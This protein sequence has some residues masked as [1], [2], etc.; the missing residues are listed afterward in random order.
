M[1]EKEK[2]REGERK[3]KVSGRGKWREGVGG[4]RE[5]ERWGQRSKR[6]SGRG[7]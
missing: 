6:G 2:M 3:R 5:W 7:K 1:R 4:V